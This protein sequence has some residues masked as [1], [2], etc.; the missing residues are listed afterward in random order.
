[1]DYILL[2]SIICGSII[3]SSHIEPLQVIK[4]KLGLLPY[5]KTYSEYTIIN[6]I[7]KGLRHITNCPSCISH[8]TTFILL[9][10]SLYSFQMGLIIYI[11]TYLI[12]KKINE[13]KL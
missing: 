4:Q 5:S 8:W 9:N 7:L 13:I 3:F 6:I 11:I 10:P 1:M 2:I 12:D